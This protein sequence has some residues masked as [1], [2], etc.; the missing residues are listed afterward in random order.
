[1][2]FILGKI[3]KT[4]L[5]SNLNKR[6]SSWNILQV[7]VNEERAVDSVHQVDEPTRK[8]PRIYGVKLVQGR[9]T[10]CRAVKEKKKKSTSC[11]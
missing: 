10:V 3:I 9:S 11:S 4:V 5:Y 1:M 8:P 2:K 6:F 7:F